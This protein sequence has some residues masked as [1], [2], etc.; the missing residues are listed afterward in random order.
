MEMFTK[1]SKVG[2]Q[3]SHVNSCILILL[4]LL[5]IVVSGGRVR[6]GDMGQGK[7]LG[8]CDR[9]QVQ[10]PGSFSKKPSCKKE[11]IL[12]FEQCNVSGGG[13]EKERGGSYL[14]ALNFTAMHCSSI[15]CCVVMCRIVQCRT[16]QCKTVQCRTV[17]CII[18]QCI[19]LQCIIVQCIIVQCRIVHC[20]TVH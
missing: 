16:V 8:H 10:R 3:N 9:I 5:P 19:I 11:K 6:L 2:E 7:Q 14:I 17:Q 18:L 1:L 15:Q 13:D 12:N 20:R 4:R